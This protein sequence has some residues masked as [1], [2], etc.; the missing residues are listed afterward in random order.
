MLPTLRR[1]REEKK[2]L[3]PTDAYL[4]GSRRQ[5]G[6]AIAFLVL[7]FVFL[8]LTL[9]TY[10]RLLLVVTFDAGLVPLPAESIQ[11]RND[12]KRA[13]KRSRHSKTVD[14]ESLRYNVGPQGPS[15]QSP[16]L[17]MY[18]TKDAFVCES[19]G[20]PRW[21]PDCMAFKPDRGHHSSEMDRCVYKMDHFCPWVG[22]MVAEPCELSLRRG[23]KQPTY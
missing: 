8:L 16:G 9:S 6:L 2:I 23:P 11:R 7:Y 4:L 17:E 21:C 10:L 22:G 14:V 5:T 13:A 1:R 12:A 3:T 19:D 15:G 20:R 18:Y